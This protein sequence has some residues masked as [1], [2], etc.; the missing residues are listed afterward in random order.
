MDESY[1]VDVT[2]EDGEVL[3]LRNC[4]RRRKRKPEVNRPTWLSSLARCVAPRAGDGP[5]IL[6]FRDR[7]LL[8]LLGKRGIRREWLHI[9]FHAV[10]SVRTAVAKVRRNPTIVDGGVRWRRA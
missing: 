4:L 1:K 3:D 5:P 2:I 7:Q 9:H 8:Y 10:A 6:R